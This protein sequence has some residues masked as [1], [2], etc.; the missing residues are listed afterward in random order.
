MKE[1]NVKLQPL[2]SAKQTTLFT[3]KYKGVL[4]VV[5]PRPLFPF[6]APQVQHLVT[7]TEAKELKMQWNSFCTLA[8]PPLA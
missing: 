2:T 5:P 1:K 6:S 8:K 4:D 7:A 3:H